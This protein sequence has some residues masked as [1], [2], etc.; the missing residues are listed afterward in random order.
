MDRGDAGRD[1]GTRAETRR[2][3][4]NPTSGTADHV[5]RARRLAAEHG[6]EVVETERAGHAVELAGEAV[7]DGAD[8]L[9]VC[10]GDGTLHEVLQGLVA[11]D[12]LDEVTLAIVP[13]GTEN[14]S[15]ADL[16]IDDMEAGFEVAE[17]GE[18]RRID[19]GLAGDEPFV[20]SAIAG[21]PAEASS[22][23]THN[24]KKRLGSLAF[25]VAGVEEAL[26]FDG[27]R[28]EVDAASGDSE[29]I[30]QGEALAVLIG[31]VRRFVG[32]GGQA[33][34]EDGLLEATI[35]EEMPR[36][37]SVAEAIEQRLLH[38]DSPHVRTFLAESLDIVD[39]DGDPLTFSLDGEIRTYDGVSVAVR[40]RA[41]RV[42]VGEGYVPDPDSDLASDSEGDEDA[43]SCETDADPED[44]DDP[45][46]DGVG[47]ADGARST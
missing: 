24:L 43:F 42:R 22:L 12:A 32:E 13:A 45:D 28:V 19:L 18:T 7:A 1:D 26:E 30:W 27:L 15:A 40:P 17:R 37:R 31:N 46:V 23:A 20:M 3:V 36:G 10:G 16:G 38:R 14:I 9:A 35:V 6:F 5:E 25:I 2:L 41:L 8:L 29:F 39:L 11:A 33:D 4:L 21:F 47:E 44:D 34:A